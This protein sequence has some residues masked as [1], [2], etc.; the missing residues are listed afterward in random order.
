MYSA[1][2]FNYRALMIS[3]HFRNVW[4][5]SFVLR[6]FSKAGIENGHDWIKFQ[7]SS[8]Y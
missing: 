2:Q 5:K 4:S 7:L 1:L 6:L 3:N 8:A